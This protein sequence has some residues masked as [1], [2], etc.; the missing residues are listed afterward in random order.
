MVV[1]TERSLHAKHPSEQEVLLVMKLP[2]THS[3]YGLGWTEAVT[4]VWEGRWNKRKSPGS[5]G[6]NECIG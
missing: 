5:N 2:L 1:N 4:Q 6:V 3:Q